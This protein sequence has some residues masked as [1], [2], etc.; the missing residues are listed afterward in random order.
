MKLCLCFHQC[1]QFLHCKVGKVT[2]FGGR[3]CYREQWF[4]NCSSHYFEGSA[5]GMVY[6]N[7]YGILMLYRH[8]YVGDEVQQVIQI[9]NIPRTS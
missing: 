2:Y 7:Q 6:I 5:M 3:D 9:G 4:K 8:K 1:C